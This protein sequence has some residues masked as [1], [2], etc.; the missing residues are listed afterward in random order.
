MSRRIRKDKIIFDSEDNLKVEQL[1]AFGLNIEE[2][3]SV[4]GVSSDTLYRRCKEG[5]IDLSAAI[6][7]GRAKAIYKVAE[8]AFELAMKGDSGMIKYILSCKGGWVQNSQVNQDNENDELVIQRMNEVD[9]PIMSIDFDSIN[10][11]EL[12]KLDDYFRFAKSLPQKLTSPEELNNRT[13]GEI[14]G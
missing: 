1:A 6:K 11:E 4:F 14:N 2:I 12:E 5:D 8:K 3:G 9:R 7:R 13:K 10:R